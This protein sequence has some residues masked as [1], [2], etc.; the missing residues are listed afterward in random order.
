VRGGVE[1]MP[2]SKPYH[3]SSLNQARHCSAYAHGESWTPRQTDTATAATNDGRT[4]HAG[5]AE[6]VQTDA[7]PEDY[8]SH[9]Y[10]DTSRFIDWIEEQDWWR[11]VMAAGPTVESPKTL[12]LPCGA[13]LGGT[14]DLVSR[15]PDVIVVL[16]WK[17][18]HEPEDLPPMVEDYQMRAYGAMCQDRGTKDRP[19]LVGRVLVRQCRVEWLELWTQDE[20]LDNLAK[21]DHLVA[22]I[23]M[24]LQFRRG[25]HCTTCLRLGQCPA[26]RAS[27][28]R[29]LPARV[30]DPALATP[31]RDAQ[32]LLAL[33]YAE[34][35][36]ERERS[37]IRARARERETR[38][39]I[40]GREYAPSWSKPERFV[41]SALALGMLEHAIGPTAA[42]EAVSLSKSAIKDACWRA[43]MA[44]DETDALLESM[45][46]AGAVVKGDPVERF[47]WR[48]VRS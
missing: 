29:F 5:L 12:T 10:A 33:D 45:R 41:D 42:H 27:G 21:V 48:K 22:T 43:G 24:D 47:G 25:G 32:Y 13:Q 18:Y 14:P 37:I 19:V 3:P 23:D 38:P 26:W 15:P 20:R 4:V 7:L 40:G 34:E 44:D 31:E 46:E 30:T 28:A 36:I 17:W 39:I 2:S 6:W 11:T 1:R 9:L 16:D 35:V 8:P